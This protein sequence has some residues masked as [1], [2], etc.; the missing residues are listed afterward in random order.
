MPVPGLFALLRMLLNKH[1]MNRREAIK[2]TALSL[3]GLATIPAA[4]GLTGCTPGSR[5]NIGGTSAL[6]GGVS[7]GTYFNNVTELRNTP[8]EMGETAFLA[9]YHEVN[10]GGGSEIYWDSD[11]T[12]SDDNGM[13]FKADGVNRGRW[14][15][16][17]IGYISVKWF[18]ARG[19]GI[20]RPGRDNDVNYFD[21]CFKWIANNSIKKI[22]VPK[23]QYIFDHRIPTR[24]NSNHNG[25][26]FYGDG[27]ESELKLADK[28]DTSDTAPLWMLAFDSNSNTGVPLKDIYIH[29]LLF[30]GN[31]KGHGLTHYERTG[32]GL[33]LIGTSN[34]PAGEESKNIR[35]ARVSS[36]NHTTSG[37]QIR[38][39]NT[40]VTD[41]FATGTYVHGIS[42]NGNPE[43]VLI[44]N[45][46]AYKCGEGR[47]YGLD[48]SAG[49]HLTLDGFDIDGCYQGY[50]NS[51]GAQNITLKNGTIRNSIY[52]SMDQSGSTN[53]GS[54][55]YENVIIDNNQGAS[56]WNVAQ[57]IT[58]DK[59]SSTN[60]THPN[61]TSK[62]G[63]YI[64]TGIKKFNANDLTITNAEE[65]GI[66]LWAE[67]ANL[68]NLNIDGAKG[69][70]QGR[71]GGNNVTINGGIMKNCGNECI[72]IRGGN[73]NI[74]N[75]TFEGRLALRVD[76][77][78][79]VNVSGCNFSKVSNNNSGSGQVYYGSG[80]TM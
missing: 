27:D 32:Y 15:R 19:D 36:I 51:V 29:D 42:T 52:R 77:G 68:S 33:Y 56:R 66:R 46:K 37:G 35:V 71:S 74:S 72:H 38:S 64:N 20:N 76:S 22:Y 12:E 69:G 50:K 59:F 75:V 57:V 73:W 39:S 14:K 3:G 16:P 18:G 47:G 1:S 78:A 45:L 61:D 4:L 10:D 65:C 25:L 23:G 24:P 43:N 28:L 44:K 17:N 41:W 7:K 63:L 60:I 2:R 21:D 9:G 13:V 54:I 48:F 8:G 62:A 6:I 40:V 53:A 79:S 30:N 49:N 26:E 31:R 11:S 34:L 5:S 55:K 67:E 70:I 80:N 58:L